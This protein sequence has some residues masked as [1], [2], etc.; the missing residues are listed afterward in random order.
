MTQYLNYEWFILLE[1][2]AATK[3]NFCC[4]GFVADTGIPF[5]H[6]PSFTNI[7]WHYLSSSSLKT[8]SF[9]H[10]IFY[11]IFSAYH[12]AFKFILILFY[13]HLIRIVKP[14]LIIGLHNNVKEIKCP[15]NKEDYRHTLLC[16]STHPQN[17]IPSNVLAVYT[18]S[19]LHILSLNFPSDYLNE[20]YVVRPAMFDI[21][22]SSNFIWVGT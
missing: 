10:C 17:G 16:P 12:R 21:Y 7:Y 14:L 15:F 19:W 8:K 20:V 3:S 13:S 4:C 6:L 11:S 22:C 9:G 2:L 5:H 18:I 1:V